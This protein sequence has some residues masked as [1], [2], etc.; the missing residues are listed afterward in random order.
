MPENMLRVRAIVGD[1]D[2][3]LLVYIDGKEAKMNERAST[4]GG[5]FPE[6]VCELL[7]P[8]NAQNVKIGNKKIPTLP[9]TIKKIVIVGNTGCRIS[10]SEQQACNDQVEWLI[11]EVLGSVAT[12]NPGFIIHVGDYHYREHICKDEEKCGKVYGDNFAAWEAEWF[13]P[14]QEILLQFPFLFMRGNHENCDRTHKG[15]FRYLDAYPFEN[16]KCREFTGSWIFNTGIVQ[17]YV[18]DSA[19]GTDLNCCLSEEVSVQGTG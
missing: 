14:A 3:C 17:F 1:K 6:K 12:H 4:E 8:R 19:Y 7:I 9:T 13:G 11:R 15:W 5:A 10:C 16:E 18:F 2:E